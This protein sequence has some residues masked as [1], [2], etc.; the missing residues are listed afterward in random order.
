MTGALPGVTFWSHSHRLRVS[1]GHKPEYGNNCIACT[2]FGEIVFQSLQLLL[3][4][5]KVGSL[6]EGVHKQALSKSWGLII[7]L[8][9][10][11]AIIEDEL[12]TFGGNVITFGGPLSL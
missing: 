6:R 1:S 10:M 5:C 4:L 3:A 9:K 2:A 7:I 11:L 8:G 12:V